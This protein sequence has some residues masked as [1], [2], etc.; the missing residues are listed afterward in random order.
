MEDC[1]MSDSLLV[2]SKRGFQRR[3]R[4]VLRGISAPTQ[5]RWIDVRHE[6]QE[7]LS[8]EPVD[9]EPQFALHVKQVL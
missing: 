3:S 1:A 6:L 7:G 5:I 4:T 9:I 8:I 2:E